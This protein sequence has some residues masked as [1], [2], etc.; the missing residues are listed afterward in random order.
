MT[1]MRRIFGMKIKK[2]LLHIGL[3]IAVI[4]S[5]VFSAIIWIDPA[6]FQRTTNT[7]TTTNESGNSAETTVHYDMADVF[8][9][10]GSATT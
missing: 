5:L 3:L 7:T 8:S 1:M 2:Y 10:R 9:P 4:I 6:T